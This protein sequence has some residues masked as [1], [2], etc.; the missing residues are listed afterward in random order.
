MLGTLDFGKKVTAIKLRW[1]STQ[2]N[3]VGIE[4]KDCFHSF[5]IVGGNLISS[6]AEY[7]DNLLP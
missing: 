1:V 3:C 2:D 6:I 5:P 7:R 4:G